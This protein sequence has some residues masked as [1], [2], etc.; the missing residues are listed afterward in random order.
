M[1]ILK[2]WAIHPSYLSLM[3]EFIVWQKV[4]DKRVN[5]EINAQIAL[6]TKLMGFQYMMIS[7]ILSV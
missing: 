2:V 7:E 4:V 3:P 5:N 1:C 6:P